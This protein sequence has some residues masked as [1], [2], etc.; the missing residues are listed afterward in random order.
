MHLG[1]GEDDEA[2]MENYKEL[3]IGYDSTL[4]W[5]RRTGNS[6]QLDNVTRT[7][8]VHGH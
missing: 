6:S 7:Q 8:T 2:T 4:R 3:L 5:V 1:G